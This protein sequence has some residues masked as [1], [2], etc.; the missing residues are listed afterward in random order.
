MN[1]LMM[2]NTYKPFVGGVERSVEVFTEAYRK[3]GHRVI[4]VAPTFKNIPD[5][6]SDI[7][8]VP[9]I[10]NFNGTDFSVQLPIPG[11]LS[12]ALRGFKPDIVHSHHPYLIGDTAIR[13]AAR[14]VSPLVLTFHTFYEQYT[15][16]VPGNSPVLRRF[17][18]ALS[19]G[20]ANLCNK[21]FAPSES[22][23]KELLRRGVT[24]SIKII[25][26]G[27]DVEFY[28]TGDKRRWR[29]R[30]GVP[31]DGFVVG[32][33]SRIAPEKNMEFLT[34]AVAE[35]LQK[36]PQA[37]FF[38]I[39][40]G[41]SENEVREAFQQ[42]NLGDRVHSFGVLRGK[43]L[44]D[45]YHAM[46][47]FAFASHTETQGMVVA[48]AMAAGVPVVALDANG[49][50]EVV[51]DGNNGR[52]LPEED[53]AAFSSALRWIMDLSEGERAAL[54]ENARNRAREFSKE[55]CARRALDCYTDL[56]DKGCVYGK[57]EDKPLDEIRR[58]ITAEW[59]LILA[60]T[61]AT[62]AALGRPLPPDVTNK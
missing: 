13:V 38:L 14:F 43:E 5:N 24:A 11:V 30:V 27:V 47:V 6:E 20:F 26:T 1:I 32:F 61:R 40:K 19:T 51:E 53:I 23:A 56:L 12:K 59:D 46:D 31:P 49:V 15:H 48:E 33:V 25:P 28:S 52:L 22:V 44:V 35:F 62:G 36:S 18:I 4:I 3:Q 45:A 9:A 50:R 39:G 54:K 57:A 21:V 7:I 34:K 41:P 37:H 10:Q 58:L 16:Y 2:T 55:H 8:R 29:Q 42:R 60:K 17:V